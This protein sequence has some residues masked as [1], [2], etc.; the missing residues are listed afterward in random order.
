MEKVASTKFEKIDTGISASHL[1]FTGGEDSMYQYVDIDM[2]YI[3]IYESMYPLID[4]TIYQEYS[5]HN[6]IFLTNSYYDIVSKDRKLHSH[7]LYEFTF[8]LSGELDMQ[9]ENETLT[10][11]PGDCCL[12]NKN[13]HHLELIDKTCEFVLFL[14]KEEFLFDIC[15]NNFF[16]DADGTAHAL[17][18]I[19]DVF[20]DENRKNPLYDAKI[21]SDFRLGKTQ[22][23]DAIIEIINQMIDEITLNKSGKSHMMK[24]LFCELFELMLDPALYDVRVHRA[25]LS[26]DEQIVYSIANAYRKKNGIFSRDEIEKLVG[27]NGDYVERVFK[28]S[29]GKTL[30]EY[31]RDFM[32]QKAASLLSDTDMKIGEICE[33]LG[34]TNRHYFNQIFADKYGLTPSAYRKG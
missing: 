24:A 4:R 15:A 31:G 16:Y 17:D 11:E 18:T 25:K 10:Y 23:S 1:T 34:Y 8:V 27:Y 14:L 7:N 29:T 3:I 22:N 28:R 5:E 12:C 20:V 2:P 9:I 26:N 6:R 32:L 21:Y 13:I 30:K 19:F 33:T